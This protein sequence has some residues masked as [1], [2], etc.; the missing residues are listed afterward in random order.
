MRRRPQIAVVGAGS[1]ADHLAP[2]AEELGRA[3]V[4]EGYRVVCGGLGGV[5][6]AVA[7]GAR[8]SEA[9]SGSDVIGLL[10]S[11]EAADANP[12]V[13]IVIPTGLSHGRNLL[14]VASADVVVVVGGRAGTLSEVA[15]AWQLGKPVVA[16]SL[17][18]GWAERVAG[19]AIDDRRPD[20]VVAAGSVREALAAVRSALT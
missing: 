10:P 19:Q 3:L 18:G 12:F 13:D 16:L 7:R 4:D 15:L 20:T 14:V 5:M 8:A 9:A 2:V 17:T 11:L 1:R 6:E